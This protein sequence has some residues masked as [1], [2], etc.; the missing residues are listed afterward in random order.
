M[1]TSAP[2]PVSEYLKTMY[3]PDCDYIDGEVQERNLGEQDHSDL[4][5][6]IAKLLGTDANEEYLWVNTELRVQVKPTRFRVPD[7][8]VRRADAPSEQ[9]VR[10]PPLLC[11]E[12][13]SPEDT[14]AKMR[15]KVRDYLEMG[16]PE[17]WVVEP[18]AR[19]VSIYCGAT[20]VEMS[21]GELAVPHTPVVV[22][23]ADIFKVLDRSR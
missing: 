8:C 19:N 5:T 20:M 6:R 2:I 18:E 3:H 11:V 22:A 7:V 16:V 10:T 4:Q 9:I 12:V 13:L 1:A 17:V 15:T 21:A 14:V 23:L